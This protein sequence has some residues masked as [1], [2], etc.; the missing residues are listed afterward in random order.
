MANNMAPSLSNGFEKKPQGRAQRLSVDRR[1]ASKVLPRKSLEP[2]GRHALIVRVTLQDCRLGRL[3]GQPHETSRC[4]GP[5]LS[6]I[7]H[8]A[9]AFCLLSCFRV[10]GKSPS[11]GADGRWGEWSSGSNRDFKSCLILRKRS[12]LRHD[13]SLM[14]QKNSLFTNVGNLPL[15]L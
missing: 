2:I 13:D 10:E 5:G 6:C 11:E 8:E 9:F 3:R 7:S 1:P 12:L 15:S 4:R 14:A